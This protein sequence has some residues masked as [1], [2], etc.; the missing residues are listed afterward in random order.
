MKLSLVKD[1]NWVRSRLENLLA[2]VLMFLDFLGDLRNWKQEENK[3][4][5]LRLTTI[6]RDFMHNLYKQSS[7]TI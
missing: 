4:Q 3:T 2:L 7:K 1:L 5:K 6:E